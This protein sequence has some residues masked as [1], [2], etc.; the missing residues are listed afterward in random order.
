[1]PSF[2]DIELVTDRLILRP[3]RAGDLDAWTAMMLDEE[4]ARFIGGAVPR[5]LSWRQLMTVIG[6]WHAQGSP[7]RS[8]GNVAPRQEGS[9]DLGAL[10]YSVVS[11]GDRRDAG[12]L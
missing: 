3:P 9:D 7:W 11:A 10:Y 5:P 12:G 6:S 2:D 1:M 8:G 4:T